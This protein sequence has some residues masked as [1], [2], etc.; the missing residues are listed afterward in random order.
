MKEAV[1]KENK[2]YESGERNNNFGF[3][4]LLSAFMVIVGHMYVL[5]GENAPM[6]IY[7]PIHA[8]GVASFFSIGGYLITKSWMPC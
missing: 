8:L 1:K 4:R 2:Q 7:V 5:A 6:I 3:V